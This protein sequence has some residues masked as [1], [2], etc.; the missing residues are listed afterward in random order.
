MVLYFS[1]LNFLD[2]NFSSSRNTREPK[3]DNVTLGLTVR[4]GEQVFGVVHVFYSFSDTVVH[5]TDLTGRETLVRVTGRMKV[6]DGRYAGTFAA[7]D[8]AQ[9]CKELGITAIHVKLRLRATGGIKTKNPAPG[10]QSAFRALARSGLKIGR[11]EDVT[12]IPTNSTRR[13]SG[14]SGRRQ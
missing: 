11:I 5:A 10:V 3:E 1:P 14:R 2:Y 9:R 7:Q 8:V 13:K 4:E 12:L 6:K